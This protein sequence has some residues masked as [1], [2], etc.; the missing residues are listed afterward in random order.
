MDYGQEEAK[1]IQGEDPRQYLM[2]TKSFEANAQGE[3]TALNVVGVEWIEQE[4]RKMPREVA[5]SESRIE[6][7]L[8]LLAM[9]FVGPWNS[10]KEVILKQLMGTM[11]LMNQAYL[12]LVIAGE[13][14]VLLS[15]L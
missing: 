15:G 1:A 12:Q 14:R 9:G 10:M 7:D 8:V 13:V 11:K 2:M 3:V 5:G 6:A 4:G